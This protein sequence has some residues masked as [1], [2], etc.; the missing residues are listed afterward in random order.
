[1]D[2]ALVTGLSAAA[3]HALIGL[4]QESIQAAALVVSGHGR[5]APADD[6]VWS[7]ATI[8]ADAVAIGVGLACAARPASA[9][10]RAAHPRRRPHCGLLARGDR[11][12]RRPRGPA[13]RSR[14]RPGSPR[15]FVRGERGG[16]GRARRRQHVART[17]RAPARRRSAARGDPGVAREVDRDRPRRRRR[18]VGVRCGG[19]RPRRSRVRTRSR[20]CSPATRRCGGRSGTRPRSPDSARRPVTSQSSGSHRIENV[21]ESVQAAFDIA[22]PNPMASGSYESLVPFDTLSRAGRALRL[23]D[24]RPRDP[25]RRDG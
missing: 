1:M 10:P 16:R 25:G 21:Q 11:H 19:A 3:N 17:P 2:Q 13:A 23:D 20:A 24:D 9:T 7:R 22:P 8:A 14:R 12:R 5:H 18:H 4:V 15:P 6:R